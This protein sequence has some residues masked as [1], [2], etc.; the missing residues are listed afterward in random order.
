MAWPALRNRTVPCFR[1][2]GEISGA[3]IPCPT[4]DSLA[5]EALLRLNLTQEESHAFQSRIE[6]PCRGR[7]RGLGV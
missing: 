4:L 1:E 3:P 5:L 7:H 2:L 6:H